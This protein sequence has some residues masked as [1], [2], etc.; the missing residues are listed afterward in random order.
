M[1][2]WV[3]AIRAGSLLTTEVPFVES[4]LVVPTGR[5]E[6]AEEPVGAAR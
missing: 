4:H 2:I 5:F 6:R 1:R 3:K